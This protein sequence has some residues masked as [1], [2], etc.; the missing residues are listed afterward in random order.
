MEK[1]SKEILKNLYRPPKDSHKGQ[2]GK[3]TII[4]GSRLFH[5]ASLW[6]L[7][8]ASRIVDMVFYSTVAENEELAKRLKGEVYD[9]I[10]MP[11]S[12]VED[13]I[14]ESDTILIGPGL[15]RE[16][17]SNAKCKMKNE[18]LKFKI[19]KEQIN[20]EEDTRE[21]TQYLLSKFPEKKWVIDAGSLQMMEAEW[22]KKLANVIITPHLGEFRQLFKLKIKK[23]KFKI[24]MPN[25]K[26]YKNLVSVKARK[27]GCT[28]V[29]KGPTDIVCDPEKCGYNITGNEGMTKGGTGD[30]L[31]GLIAALA[32]KNDLFLAA[33]AGVYIGG[34][35][36]DR[37]YKKVGP[38]FNASDLCEEIPKLLKELMGYRNS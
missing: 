38:Y 19:K 1:I 11:R 9:F 7:K 28:I 33:S 5:G 15:M 24:A 13:Y 4:G 34:L 20:W 25:L 16:N 18:K 22:L 6:A 29:L 35:A 10:C 30:V 23:E 3:L 17:Q 14:K 37:L 26:F 8:T 2:N 12:E 31:A 21:I 36:G 32:C 27:Y